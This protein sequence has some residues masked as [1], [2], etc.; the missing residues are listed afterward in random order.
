MFGE[1]DLQYLISLDKNKKRNETKYKHKY[2]KT[3]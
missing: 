3:K 2:N 1:V